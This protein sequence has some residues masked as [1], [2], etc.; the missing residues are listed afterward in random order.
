MKVDASNA[1]CGP[2]NSEMDEEQVYSIFPCFQFYHNAR[3]RRLILFISWTLWYV[4][5][6]IKFK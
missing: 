1:V 5:L 4:G 3:K 6:E 2:I